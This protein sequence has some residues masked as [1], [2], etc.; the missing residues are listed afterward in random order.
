MALGYG[1]TLLLCGLAASRHA[2]RQDPRFLIAVTAPWVLMFALLPGMHQRYLVW[3]SGLTAAGTP[4]GLA[5]AA[6]HLVVT[7]IGWGMMAHTQLALAPGFAPR[8]LRALGRLYPE[9]GG[10]VLLACGATLLTLALWPR[11]RGEK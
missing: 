5:P 11:R 9:T 7:T 10:W 3:G 2:R 6:V 1:T 8:L 4:L